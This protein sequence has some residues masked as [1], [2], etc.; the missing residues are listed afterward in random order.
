MERTVFTA[1]MYRPGIDKG[2]DQ[3]VKIIGKVISKFKIIDILLDLHFFE[4][5]FKREK[6]QISDRGNLRYYVHSACCF[7]L[8]QGVNFF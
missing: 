5:R 2:S 6:P 3:F 7:F 1:G 4:G 8:V